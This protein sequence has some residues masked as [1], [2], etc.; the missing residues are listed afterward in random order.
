MKKVLGVDIGG[1]KIRMGIVDADGTVHVDETIPTIT[2]LYPYLEEQV[3]SMMARYP[4]IS[5]IGIGTRGMVDA[6]NGIITFETATLPGWQ[7]THV[8]SQLEKA[9]GLRVEV[10]NDANCAALAEATIG[11]AKGI[12][13]V[14][15]LTVGTGLGGGFVFDNIVM[16]GAHGGAGE[17]GHMTL[18]P[19]G[20]ACTC[21]RLGCNEQY[22]SGTA[23]NRMI[24]E[25]NLLDSNG[26]LMKSHDLFDSAKAGDEVAKSI[27]STFVSD[28]ASV[29]STIQA[30]LDMDVVV[31]GGG[32][33]DSSEYWWNDLLEAL[34]PLLLKPLEL[35]KA[36]FGNEAGMLGAA[37][38]V[39]ENVTVK[40]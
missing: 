26:I 12:R 20:Y 8:K 3:L 39:Q 33:A 21:G 14:V 13:R 37:M 34:Q 32:V 17:V 24:A 4:E 30:A 9:T 16:N 25:K 18:Y 19:R 2:P 36:V 15:C 35:K 5:A 22:V 31:I 6:E 7:G 10:N 23:L 11:A 28:F 38:L 1:T 27:I 40:A 29:I